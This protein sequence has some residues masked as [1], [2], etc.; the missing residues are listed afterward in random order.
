MGEL[1][2][3]KVLF[4]YNLRSLAR[5]HHSRGVPTLSKPL[6]PKITRGFHLQLRNCCPN[7]R[8]TAPTIRALIAGRFCRKRFS[9]F[10]IQILA[11]LFLSIVFFDTAANLNWLCMPHH[12]H[13][14]NQTR[15]DQAW[16]QKDPI[17][18]A[19]RSASQSDCVSLF[20]SFF[21]LEAIF[22]YPFNGFSV[23]THLF[24]SLN[25]CRVARFRHHDRSRITTYGPNV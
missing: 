6:S 19:A 3:G 23:L 13:V 9:F 21:L 7:N 12:D 4:P 11:S 16:T 15:K 17:K 1:T 14:P 20:S 2:E 8:A 18:E 5:Y 25:R 10:K 22:I 24:V